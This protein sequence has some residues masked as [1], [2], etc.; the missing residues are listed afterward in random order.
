MTGYGAGFK[1]KSCLNLFSQMFTLGIQVLKQE[2]QS[3]Q[4]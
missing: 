4:V 3:L 1:I 2:T